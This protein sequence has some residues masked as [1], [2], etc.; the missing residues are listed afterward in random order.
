MFVDK[1][2]DFHSDVNLEDVGE[3]RMT[4]GAGIIV[5]FGNNVRRQED[6]IA[7]ESR[8]EGNNF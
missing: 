1:T 3:K 4:N 8:R 5:F 2:I 7:I 6:G